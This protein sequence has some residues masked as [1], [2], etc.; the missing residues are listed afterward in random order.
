[1]EEKNLKTTVMIISQHTV[2]NLKMLH[3][4]KAA[5]LYRNEM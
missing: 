2:L 1:M 4:M 3:N 5:T